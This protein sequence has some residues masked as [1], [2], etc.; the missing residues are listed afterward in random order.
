MANYHFLNGDA[1]LSQF[2]AS[3]PGERLV[4]REC[5]V[6]GPVRAPDLEAFFRMRADFLKGQYGDVVNLD[7]A[8]AV[9]GELKRTREIP[10]GDKVCLWFEDDLFCQVNLWFTVSLLQRWRPATPVWLVRP[11]RHTPYAFGGLSGDELREAYDNRRRL[12]DP[13]AFADLWD[14]Y[15]LDDRPR[16]RRTAESMQAAHPYILPAVEAHLDRFPLDGRAGRPERVL[17]AI[18]AELGTADVGPVFRE[19]SRRAGI[20]GF[21]DLQVQRLLVRMLG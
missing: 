4:V 16:L 1:L 2:P 8:A 21:G 20:Y 9:A 19:F 7:Y 3:V 12:E 15:R 18:V 10:A 13:G 14:A 11:P 5:L 6:Q 17:R